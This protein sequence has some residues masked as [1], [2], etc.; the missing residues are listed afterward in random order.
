MAATLEKISGNTAEINIEV[1]VSK[2]KEGVGKAY[3]KNAKHFNLPGF[4]KG[5]APQKMIEQYYGEGIFYEDAVNILLPEVYDEAVKALALEPVDRPD[6]DV[7][8]IG[9]GKNLILSV[10]VTVKPEVKLG[11]YKGIKIKKVEYNVTDDDVEKELSGLRERNSRMV[12]VEDR[13]VQNGDIVNIDFKGYK[14]DVAFPGGEGTSYDLT[15][16]SGQFIPGFEEQL[17]GSKIGDDAVVNVTFPEDYHAED[18]KGASVRFDVKVN[19]IKV[20]ELPALDDEL[21]KDVS[22]FDTLDELKTNIRS[23]LEGQADSKQQAETEAAAIDAVLE[24]VEVDVPEC[25]IDTRIEGM[26]RDYDMRLTGQGLSLEKY[27]EMTG[28]KPDDFKTQFKTK[29]ES[30]V[31]ATLMLEAVAKAEVVEVSGEELETEYKNLAELYK[32]PLED[33]K[34]YVA[35]AELS[36]D[37]VMKKTVELIVANAVIK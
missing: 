13:A 1:E 36:K 27:M 8:Q 34:K 28:M 23:R 14:D 7:V 20:K 35:E 5:K 33:V 11:K 31:K 29:A 32:M 10:K 30:D 18:L 25:M 9:S 24:N 26:L 17:I 15:I 21:A 6:V 4:R 16:G 12:S 22:E 37:L 19:G 3:L 2:F